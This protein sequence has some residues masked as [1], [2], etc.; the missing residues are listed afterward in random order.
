LIKDTTATIMVSFYDIVVPMLIT[1]IAS[2]KAILK[3]GEEH[4]TSS[5][6]GADSLLHARLID[7][8]K[9]LIFQIQRISDT[10]KNGL[11]RTGVIENVAIADNEKTFADL[12]ARLDKTLELLQSVK[13]EDF[14]SKENAEVALPIRGNQYKF[15]GV[16]YWS[17]YAVPNFFFHVSM[18]YALLRKQGVPIGKMDFLAN[19]LSAA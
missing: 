13:K 3:K 17:N 2:T 1:N 4:A 11:A 14:D 15:T 9:D 7:D 8:M 19:P 6:A 12:Y 18:A 16:K 5:G 10:V